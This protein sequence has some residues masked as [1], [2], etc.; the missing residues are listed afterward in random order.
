VGRRKRPLP[1]IENLEITDAGAEGKA[2]GR[3]NERVVFVPFAAPG[4]VVD[5]QVYKKRKSFFEARIER[6]EKASPLR[7][8]PKCSHF[9]LCGGCKWQ[10]LDYAQ[11]LKYKQKQV[12]D[13][14][15]RI[16]RVPYE[17][18]N[19]IIGSDE[20]FNYRNKLEFTF[21]NRRWLTEAELEKKEEDPL[22]L[23]GLGFHLPGMFDKIL[24][25]DE[26]Y[27]Q[28]DPSNNI[29]LALKQY[30]VEKGI[31]F[32]D[33]KKWEGMM[34]NLIVRNTTTGDLMT[35]V[36][37][38][39]FDKET[40]EGVMNFLKDTFPEITSL[41]Y[42][43]N[44]KKNDTI[45]DLEIEVF[46][47]TPYITET[48]QSGVEGLRPLQFRIGPKSFY[49][50]NSKQAYHLYKAAFDLAQF[51][52][53]ELVYDLYTGTGTIA[54]FIARSV[55][56]VVGV[57]YVK[58]AVADA[59]VNVALNGIEN[60]SFVSGDLAKVLNE[61]FLGEHGKPDVILTDPPRSGMHPKV[62][63]QILQVEPK[64]VVYVSCN[65]ATQARDVAL[66]YEKYDIKEVQPVDMFPQTHHV[67]N[68]ILLVK[69]D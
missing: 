13:A 60:A 12:K 26:C 50:T 10:H 14:L 48:M 56:K 33:V 49:Q 32:Y 15:D 43:I 34:R 69:R 52:G 38:R 51:K 46:D 40:V 20:T 2:V 54:A 65:P 17:K 24:N 66:L 53:D 30:V 67:E 25:I 19:P 21:S 18:L 5:V 47:G 7:I 68:V 39:E 45:T 37:F 23:D 8:E 4:D 29:R 36:V 31:S 64:K 6:F 22:A 27:L 16:A 61:E 55:K 58:E 3:H 62:V 44:G 57:E 35:I 1:Y 11:Q 63:E 9:G 28:K 41:L 42:V 59:R